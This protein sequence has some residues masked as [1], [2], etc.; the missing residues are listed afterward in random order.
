MASAR[1]DLVC[2]DNLV[3]QF[4][5][6]LGGLGVVGGRAH[7]LERDVLTGR[8]DFRQ[9]DGGEVAP[10]E[11]SYH[12]VLAIIVLLADLDR[13]VAAFAIVLEVL[14]LCGVCN[15]CRVA[16]RARRSRGLCLIGLGVVEWGV[17]TVWAAGQI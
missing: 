7:D 14:L 1:V 17:G 16:R 13:M 5:L 12:S 6:V 2:A 10:T 15:I 3:K 8:I 4:D 11:L 9:P